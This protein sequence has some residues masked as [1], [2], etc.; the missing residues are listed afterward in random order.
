VIEHAFD[1]APHAR[2]HS[3]AA[4]LA[5]VVAAACVLWGGVTVANALREW[6][7]ASAAARQVHAEARKRKAIDAQRAREGAASETVRRASQQLEGRLHL[8]WSGI[9]S[10]LEAAGRES[11]GEAVLMSM[12]T[13]T[14]AATGTLIGLNCVAASPAAMLKYVRALR[15]N[16]GAATTVHLVSQEKSAAAGPEGVSFQLAVNWAAP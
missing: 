7:S 2:P 4:W 15:L 10:T 13:S 5:L 1:L 9:F 16:A 12:N 6:Q 8:P 3:R 11:G 14:S